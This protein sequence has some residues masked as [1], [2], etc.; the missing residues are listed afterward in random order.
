MYLKL[1]SR[2]DG[3]A[4]RDNRAAKPLRRRR[5]ALPVTFCVFTAGT[6]GEKF[7]SRK[8]HDK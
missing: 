6:A 1:C 7:L 8:L 3:E 4:G 2:A 5:H